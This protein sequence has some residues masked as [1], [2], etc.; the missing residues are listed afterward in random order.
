MPGKRQPLD[1]IEAN[2]RKHLSQ[3][4]RQQREAQ[5]ARPSKQVRRLTPPVWL[6]VSQRKEFN[7][8]SQAL[9]DLVPKLIIR[10]DADTVATYLIAR[11]EYLKATQAANAALNDGDPKEAQAWSL[12]QDRYFKQARSCANDLGL[13]ITSRCR[14]VLP[15]KE[16]EPEDEFTAFLNR[17]RT[18]AGED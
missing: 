13:T 5:E 15:P 16:E 12:V 18:A 17:R 10:P 14:L 11:N 1:V 6:P 8:I 9:V 2:G 4:E 3:S 7:R